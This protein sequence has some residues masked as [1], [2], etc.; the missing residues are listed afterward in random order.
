MATRGSGGLQFTSHSSIH[1][2]AKEGRHAGYFLVSLASVPA[3][4]PCTTPTSFYHHTWP[5]GANDHRAYTLLHT[6]G[7]RVISAIYSCN[8]RYNKQRHLT[9]TPTPPRLFQSKILKIL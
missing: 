7:Q 6:H 2:E 9:H 3:W 4:C 8:L 5:Q 1:E